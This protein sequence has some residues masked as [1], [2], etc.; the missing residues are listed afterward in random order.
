MYLQMLF[1]PFFA[2][3]ILGEKLQPYHFVGGALILLGIVVIVLRSPKAK[4]A[5]S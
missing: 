1:V 4:A 5:T 3:L 2:Y